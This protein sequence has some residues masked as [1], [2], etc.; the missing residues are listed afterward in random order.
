MSKENPFEYDINTWLYQDPQDTLPIQIPLER[1]GHGFTMLHK[2]GYDETM[3]MGA[4][5][6]GTIELSLPPTQRNTRGLGYSQDRVRL[7]IPGIDIRNILEVMNPNQG[8]I[9]GH[10]H[11]SHI[12]P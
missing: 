7:G 1:Y 2:F 9:H 12:L 4:Q 5:Q 11:I 10:A 6:S 3:G 8:K